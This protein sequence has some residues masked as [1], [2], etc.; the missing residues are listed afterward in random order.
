MVVLWCGEGVATGVSKD[1]GT[2]SPAEPVLV[3]LQIR[4]QKVLLPF[5]KPCSGLGTMLYEVAVKEADLDFI[6]NTLAKAAE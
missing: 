2:Y 3:G 4:R 6:R 1:A 5:T